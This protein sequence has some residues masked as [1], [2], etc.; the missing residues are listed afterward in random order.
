ML[1]IIRRP[2]LPGIAALCMA[3][4]WLLPST[5]ARAATSDGSGASSAPSTLAPTGGTALSFGPGANG[6][7]IQTY[8]V[9]AEQCRLMLAAAKLSAPDSICTRTVTVTSHTVQPTASSAVYGWHYGWHH[10]DE[11]WG[12]PWD[13]CHFLHLQASAWFQWN[14]SNVYLNSN[15]ACQNLTQT[16]PYSGAITWCGNWD[17]GGY[18]NPQNNWGH[19]M[20]AGMNIHVCITFA[21]YQTCQDYFPRMNVDIW[22]NFWI[23]GG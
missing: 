8:A 22:G 10:V 11:C 16:W 5:V 14:Y 23:S 21:T 13:G 12:V 15:T 3:G 6:T 4:G 20:N 1:S 18:P 9:P 19:Y 17:N 2:M 7:K